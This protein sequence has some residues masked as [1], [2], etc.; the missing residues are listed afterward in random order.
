MLTRVESA[1]T[2]LKSSEGDSDPTEGA[3]SRDGELDETVGKV[4]LLPSVVHT[5]CMY[6][7]LSELQ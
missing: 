4:P 1:L 7:E 6:C 2:L 3:R 5:Y